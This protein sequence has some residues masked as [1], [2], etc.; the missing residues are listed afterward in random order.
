MER[1]E[2][3]RRVVDR[4]GVG[5]HIV[6]DPGADHRLKVR[7]D[8]GKIFVVD[9]EQ[10]HRRSDGTAELDGQWA[11]RATV[12]SIPRL[13]EHVEIGKKRVRRGSVM[14]QK[15]VTEDEVAIDE[16]LDQED[17]EIERVAINQF[18]DSPPGVRTEGETL[19]I[20]C[21]EEVIVYE[22]RLRVREEL[23]V[24][25]VRRE[26]NRPTTV[27]VRREEIEV[28]RQPNN[29]ETEEEELS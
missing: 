4:A 1:R 5:G 19:I 29:E 27:T 18:V 6:T 22:K 24:R 10:L 11:E 15:R 23:H 14:L 3:N 9:E 2:E 25:R 7:L 13:E 16:P 21:L 20:P 12:L 28:K 17:V 26:T 8:D